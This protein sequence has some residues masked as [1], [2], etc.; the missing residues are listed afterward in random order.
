MYDNEKLLQTLDYM[1]DPWSSD[2]AKLIRAQAAEID[3]LN[4]ELID[5]AGGAARWERR[6]LDAEA[7]LKAIVDAWEVLPGGKNYYIRE[8]EEWLINDMKPAIDKA[9]DNG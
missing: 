4:Y 6:A 5:I 8:I 7:K 2:A 1:S 9:R 3:R